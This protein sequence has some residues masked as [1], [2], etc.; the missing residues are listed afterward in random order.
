M[1][2]KARQYT[3]T[4]IRRLD[5]LSGGVCAAPDCDRKLIA[6]DGKSIISKI[7][8]IEAANKNGPRFNINMSDDE[9]RHFDNLIL[10]CD[11][12]HTII[13]NKDNEQDYPVDLLKK[14]KA[15]HEAT[16]IYKAANNSSMLERVIEIVA[17]YDTDDMEN[18][19]H[20]KRKPFEMKE[21]ITYNNLIRNKHLIDA[22]KIFYY[23]ISS[24][25]EE[26]ERDGSFAKT[27]LLR[28][29]KNIYLKTKGIY[30]PSGGI[31]EIRNNADN[32]FEKVESVLLEECSKEPNS[33]DLS[34]GVSIIMVDAFMRCKI[35][36]EPIKN[37]CR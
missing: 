28:N 5:T 13:D 10:L 20:S 30:A 11:E 23:R 37:D 7:C 3:P 21:K 31:D 4:T 22:Y 36:E 33:F 19:E 26:L 9:R 25:Y 1:G 18:I 16:Q 12:C 27:K 29:I 32:I 34:Y 2:D 15:E 14:W 24:L 17:D 8:H 35:L 6:R